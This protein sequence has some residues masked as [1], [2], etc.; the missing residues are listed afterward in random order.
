MIPYNKEHTNIVNTETITLFNG[1]VNETIIRRPNI[2][3]WDTMLAKRE[4]K[5]QVWKYIVAGI[6]LVAGV[7]AGIF[8]AG[9][10]TAAGIATAASILSGV[11]VAAVGAGAISIVLSGIRADEMFELYAEEYDKGIRRTM[12]DAI[13]NNFFGILNN[14][15]EGYV[16]DSN[17]AYPEDQIIY[18][19][20]IVNNLS[21]MSTVKA[22]LS[23]KKDF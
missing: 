20:N 21:I 12:Q 8:T 23:P 1:D 7:V 6:V 17:A 22:G 9:A 4:K 13:T 11:S 15:N 19:M 10:G 3:Y 2:I 14:S 18:Y 16:G 5:S